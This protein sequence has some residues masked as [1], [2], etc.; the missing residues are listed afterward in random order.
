MQATMRAH[1]ELEESGEARN[2]DDT[3]QMEH[4]RIRTRHDHV[5]GRMREKG[6]SAAAHTATRTDGSHGF[7]VGEP[8]YS[9]PRPINNADLADHKRDRCQHRRNRPS[10]PERLPSGYSG[11]LNHLTSHL[12]ATPRNTHTP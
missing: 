12:S 11:P 9:R 6:R 7:A 4:C 10:R 8:E 3:D 2:D 5:L 1:N